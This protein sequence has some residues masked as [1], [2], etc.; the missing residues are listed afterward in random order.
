MFPEAPLT[1]DDAPYTRIQHRIMTREELFRWRLF[2]S[3]GL[4]IPLVFTVIALV[5]LFMIG[6][7]WSDFAAL[8][9]MHV[10]VMPGIAV[11]YHRYFAHRSF[12]APRWLALT[13]AVVG[14]MMAMGPVTAWSAQHRRHHAYSDRDGDPHSPHYPFG[15]DKTLVQRLRSL[16]R[17]H[18][19][20]LYDP[21]YSPPE[22]WTPDLLGDPALLWIDKH[23]G[24][25]ALIGILAPAFVTF[26]FT[27]TWSGFYGALLWGGFV[28]TAW[29][30]HSTLMIATIPHLIGSRPFNTRDKSGNVWPLALISWGE[31][32]HNNHHAFP[33]SALT[34]LYWWQLDPAG[35]IIRVLAAFGIATDLHRPT[36]EVIARKLASK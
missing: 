21:E 23:F 9:I 11:G 34:G 28:R 8:I 19:G 20:W 24:H 2:I 22:I 16:V 35:W 30:V 5:R 1:A 36:K 31:S 27:G 18:V 10:L 17:A 7:V 13:L 14:S 33:S 29:G 4:G 32:W 3:L 26:A 6:P 25:L 12:T 15:E